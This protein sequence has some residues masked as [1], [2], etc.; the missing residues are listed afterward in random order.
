[1]KKKQPGNLYGTP[2]RPAGRAGSKKKPNVPPA[3]EFMPKQ[4]KRGK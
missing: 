3:R 4:P 2:E 1:M